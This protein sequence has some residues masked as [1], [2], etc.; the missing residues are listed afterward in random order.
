[1]S[2]ELFFVA[3]TDALIYE[4]MPQMRD[5]SASPQLLAPYPRIAEFARQKFDKVRPDTLKLHYNAGIE[6]CYVH[7]GYYNWT[8]EGCDYTLYPGDAFVT[9]PWE[10]H[11]SPIGTLNRGC[12]SWIILVPESYS[13]DGSLYL[14]PECSMDRTTQDEIGRILACKESH[15][16]YGGNICH[17]LAALQQELFRP[18]LGTRCLVNQL[19]DQLLIEVARNVQQR[20]ERSNIDADVCRL[21]EHLET[22]FAEPWDIRRM[23]KVAGMHPLTLINRCK[24]FTGN[25]PVQLLTEIRVKHAKKQMEA[26]DLP[27]TQIA[28]D[29]GFSSVQYFSETFKKLNGC[30]PK[31]HRERQKATSGN[32]GSY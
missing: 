2:E 19:T 14:G 9:C 26:T 13:R 23:A 25:T 24:R 30:P 11:G 3:N 1:M 10:L 18:A 21:I 29:C 28:Y 16:L 4:S 15:I 31:E 32:D 6:I 22:A 27:I 8:A 7:K 20:T 17:L 5:A 12:L